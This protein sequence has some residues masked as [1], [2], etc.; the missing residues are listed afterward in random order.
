MARKTEVFIG[1][2]QAS[3]ELHNL[4]TTVAI[5]DALSKPWI[6]RLQA[7][8]WSRISKAHRAMHQRLCDLLGRHSSSSSSSSNSSSTSS[9]INANF[10]QM[11]YPKVPFLGWYLEHLSNLDST[12]PKY[13][14]AAQTLINFEKY[15]TVASVLLEIEKMQQHP[16]RFVPN[17]EIIVWLLSARGWLSSERL[18][19]IIEPATTDAYV[20]LQE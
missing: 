15:A 13:I 6:H 16:Y 2:A 11:S 20:L 7:S 17:E 19:A 14:D 1:I 5:L 8:I 18:S 12:A 9:A 3:Y 10:T 4:N